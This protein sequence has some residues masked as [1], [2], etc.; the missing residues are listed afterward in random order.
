MLTRLQAPTTHTTHES[1]LFHLRNPPRAQLQVERATSAPNEYNLPSPRTYAIRPARKSNSNTRHPRNHNVDGS[2]N[3][4]PRFDADAQQRTPAQFYATSYVTSHVTVSPRYPPRNSCPRAEAT[5]HATHAISQSQILPAAQG[6]RR[7]MK[8]APR[9]VQKNVI[10]A[11]CSN[12]V[13][14]PR[15]TLR[16][17]SGYVCPMASRGYVR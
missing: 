13:I 9:A 7:A 5:Q 16:G 8:N 1:H 10:F 6:R 17:A 11:A 2:R 15:M 3:A 12:D 4:C 14:W